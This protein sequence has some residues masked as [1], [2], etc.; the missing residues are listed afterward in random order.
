MKGR[1]FM[2]IIDHDF[3]KFEDINHLNPRFIAGRTKQKIT[4]D[5]QTSTEVCQRAAVVLEQEVR[6]LFPALCKH[7][8]GTN[9]DAAL[10]M[11]GPFNK[12]RGV[13]DIVHVIEHIMIDL[14]CTL[15]DL[16]ICSGITCHYW[17]PPNRFD[18]FVESTNPKISLFAAYFATSLVR[19][20]V[21]TQRAD[22]KFSLLLEKITH[23]KPENGQIDPTQALHLM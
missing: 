13:I 3:G 1:F 12:F 2:K 22:P 6:R 8:C 18:I 17:C 20:I 19:E 10:E 4:I 15:T 21:A 16:K 5:V 11:K 7:D 23:L 9:V 14:M